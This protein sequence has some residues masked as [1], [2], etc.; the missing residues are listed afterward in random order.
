MVNK[1]EQVGGVASADINGGIKSQ[2]KVDVDMNRLQAYGLDINTI[3]STLARGKSK[4]G[5][6]TNLRRSL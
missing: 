4:L 6:R 1:I 2:I 3:V 5:G